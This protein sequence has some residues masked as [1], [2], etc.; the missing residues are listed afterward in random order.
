[1][2][3]IQDLFRDF[4]ALG[5]YNLQNAFIQKQV[6]VCRTKR[7]RTQDPHKMRNNHK[8]FFVTVNNMP[9]TV[10]KKAF[11]SI[12]GLSRSCVDTASVLKKANNGVPLPDLRGKSGSHCKVSQEKLSAVIAHVKSIPTVT[13]HYSR[14]TSP[15]VQYFPPEIKTKQQLYDLY[16]VWL[17]DRY[18]NMG[19]VTFHYYVDVLKKH[20][21]NLSFI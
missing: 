20:L 14:K 1:M 4:W 5:D 18:P 3:N 19:C 10:C 6:D 21:S 16:K 17:Q 15:N 12:F 11:L 13:S 7:W 9:V 8:H 2:D